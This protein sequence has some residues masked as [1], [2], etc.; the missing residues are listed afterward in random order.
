MKFIC[1]NSL[2]AELYDESQYGLC[3]GDYMSPARKCKECGEYYPIEEMVVI[4]P[5][6][7]VCKECGEKFS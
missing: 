7:W 6:A 3:C 2:C 5:L 4:W 1:T